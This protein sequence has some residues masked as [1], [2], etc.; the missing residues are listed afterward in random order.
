M[1]YTKEQKEEIINLRKSGLKCKEID[2]IIGVSQGYASRI[3]QSKGIKNRDCNKTINFSDEQKEIIIGKLL[4]DGY[5]NR[6]NRF[7]FTHGQ[8]QKFY[9][10]HLKNVFVDLGGQVKEITTKSHFIKD[11]FCPETTSYSLLTKS[12]K[13]IEYYHNLFYF[14]GKKKINLEIC[15]LITPRAL[16]YWYMDDG[17]Y[18]FHNKKSSL[19]YFLCTNSFSKEEVSLLCKTLKEKFNL[20][21]RIDKQNKIFFKQSQINDFKK[22]V[23]PFLLKEFYYKIGE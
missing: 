2:K 16:A 9:I 19:N 18:Y 11:K 23:K 6:K 3:C 7:H 21:T 17:S 12:F 14:S 15:N 1:K 5:I 20:N 13:S 10:E 4:G 22:I 8:K